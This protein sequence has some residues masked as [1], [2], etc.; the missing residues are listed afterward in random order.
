[1]HVPGLTR[2]VVISLCPYAQCAAKCEENDI[3]LLESETTE[4]IK[5]IHEG[6]SGDGAASGAPSGKAENG[7]AAPTGASAGDADNGWETESD[8]EDIGSEDSIDDDE[9]DSYAR[10]LLEE[11]RVQRN[12]AWGIYGREGSGKA[13]KASQDDAGLE[14]GIVLTS[15]SRRERI[16]EL[17]RCP[18]CGDY[19]DDPGNGPSGGD[20]DDSG[21][22][23]DAARRRRR[24]ADL[25]PPPVLAVHQ[26]AMT[27]KALRVL[28]LPFVFRAV[29]FEALPNHKVRLYIDTLAPKYGHL[30]QELW[31][32]ISLNENQE[33]ISIS[34]S[35]GDD[36]DAFQPQR[37]YEL[38]LELLHALPNLS[39]IDIDL[40]TTTAFLP[41][42]T[43][44]IID[45]IAERGEQLTRLCL[46]GD[47]FDQ[48]LFTSNVA[49]LLLQ[50][51]NLELLELSGVDTQSSHGPSLLRTIADMEHL[52]YLDLDDALCVNDEWAAAPWKCGLRGLALDE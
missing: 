36:P 16:V 24:M 50:L 45:C 32:R 7:S 14:S 48:R 23:S 25:P 49:P 30:V 20:N 27:S 21:S 19:H 12:H 39:K 13:G 38:A 4:M 51:P 28:A 5:Q 9:D 41:P 42:P 15:S 43:E 17:E 52:K 8:G 26:L 3:E 18:D 34:W 11:E 10:R 40:P 33:F 6:A 29:D 22:E 35:E 46:T 1:M 2:L 47:P 37:R 44:L 31:F